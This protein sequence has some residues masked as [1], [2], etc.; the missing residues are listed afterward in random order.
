MNVKHLKECNT[1]FPSTPSLQMCPNGHSLTHKNTALQ[2]CSS[3]H[4]FFT[5]L[6]VSH[7]F[8]VLKP[9]SMAKK[10]PNIL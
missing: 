2:G 10:I 7:F 4:C 3:N 6:R 9:S 5:I 8:K 1:V